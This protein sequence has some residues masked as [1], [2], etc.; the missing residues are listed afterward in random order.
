M[1]N[2]AA[3]DVAFN[4]RVLILMKL[5]EE[6][7]ASGRMVQRSG[8]VGTVCPSSED[9][10]REIKKGC[11][12]LLLGMEALDSK[13]IQRFH[14]VLEGQPNW[15]HVP[16]IV[17]LSGQEEG[18]GYEE[19]LPML[20]PLG[21]V[22]LLEGPVRM[23]TL[24]TTIRAA[25]A[26]R[27][28]Q[29][30]VRDLLVELEASRKSAVEANRAKS[31]FLANISHEI[32]T[33]LGAVLG[34]SELMMEKGVSEREKQVYMTAV[35]RNGQMLSA[36]I[37]DILDL[38]KVEAGRIEIERIEFSVTEVMA[39]VISALEPKASKKGLPLFVR[40]SERVPEMLKADPIRMKQI[41]TNIIGNAIKFTSQGSVE[42]RLDMEETGGGV[43]RLN[44]EVEDT[45]VG[46]SD[47]QA[48]RLFKPFTQA[49]TSTTR[50]YGGTGLGLV[51]S[52][53]LA[54]AMGGDLNLKWSIPGGGSCFSIHLNV[55]V[56]PQL[57][58]PFEKAMGN[59]QPQ[60]GEPLPLAGTRI[61][62]VDDSLDN[63]MLISRILR[64]LGSEVDL[65]CDGEEAIDKAMS[66]GYDV[67]LMDLQMPR[68]G[69][70]EATRRLREKGLQTPI[71]ALTAHALK[72]DRQRCLSVGCT[73][74]LTKPIQKAHLVQVLERVARPR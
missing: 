1:G 10:Y 72:D 11:G 49:D 46:I 62:V 6:A 40:R 8:F 9:V 55:E 65:A 7:E 16:V 71:V 74:Y 70:V 17:L 51:L 39:E 33:P 45:G 52:Q 27:K 12:A 23:G 63:Q 68:L 38:S 3:M 67:V 20:E 32:R 36:L 42:V 31:D 22:T 56:E 58:I 54:R 69:G 30:E 57:R 66:K 29:Y 24:V 50:R 35:K 60:T 2:I 5:P 21:N 61:L 73:D 18:Q 47:R 53:K 26:Y 59:G 34:F 28:R 25:I 44:I 64:L 43:P 48:E 4:E 15:S 19:S 13:S 41:L 37:D 14:E